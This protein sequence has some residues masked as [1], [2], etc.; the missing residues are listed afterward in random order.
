MMEQ[1]GVMAKHDALAPV[2]IDE[3]DRRFAEARPTLVRL[4]ASLIGADDADDVVHDVYLVA[5]RRI[6]QLHDARPWSRG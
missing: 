2:A 1:M 6:G 4:A 3:L 5:Q